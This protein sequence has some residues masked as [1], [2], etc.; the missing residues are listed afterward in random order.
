M[1]SQTDTPS[2]G[3]LRNIVVPV[4]D[5][6]DATAT[7]RALIPHEPTQVTVTYVVEKREGTLD[8]ASVEQ[9]EEIATDAFTV[10][11]ETFP[12][13][14]EEIKYRQDIVAAIIELADEIDA[15]AIVFRPRGGSRIKQ[16]L[17]GDTALR[18]VT[19]PDR[20]VLSLPYIDRDE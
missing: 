15:S 10:F 2:G 12:N 13:A 6:E 4:A 14:D 17:A 5:E 1:G 7:A 9:H 8:K 3:L 18:L 11:R 20:P 16:F 19:E